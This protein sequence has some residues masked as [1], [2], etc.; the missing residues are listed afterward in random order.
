MATACRLGVLAFGD[1]IT[2]GGGELQWGVA[3]QSW[4]LWTARGLGLPYTDFAS[5][6]ARAADVARA[7]LAAFAARTPAGAR[8]DVGCLHVGVNDVRP[9][10][11]DPAAFGRALDPVLA[12]LAERCERVLAC[13]LPLDLGRPPAP[14][15]AIHAANDAIESRA[16][17]H[18]ALLLDLRGFGAR[19]HVMADRVHPTAFGQIVMAE[20]ALDVLAADGAAVKVRPHS[21]VHYETT[22]IKRL[23]GDVTYVYR[24][25][26]QALKSLAARPARAAGG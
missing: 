7:Q 26:K 15:A 12:L 19:D 23:R 4:A 22:A 8:Y 11:F 6:G 21:L 20:R 16:T 18:G 1:S 10:G 2:H 24:R 9:P 17:E 25:L 3:L 14:A 13:T 5:D